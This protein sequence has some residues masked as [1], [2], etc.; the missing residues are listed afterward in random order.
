DNDPAFAT[1]GGPPGN[2]VVDPNFFLNES[3][4]VAFET[5]GAITGLS[6]IG[7]IS[8]G[9]PTNSVWSESN[10]TCG[11]IYLW[12]P[13]GGLQKI[14]AAGDAAP[15]T[16]V[17]FSCV[18]L[19]SGSPSPL[20]SSGQV[21]FTSPSPFGAPLPC[22]LCDPFNP[23]IGMNGVFLYSPGGA[24]TEI[25][26][27]NDTLPGQTQA[28]TFVPNLSVPVNSLGQVAFGAEL[29]TTSQGFYLR[30]ADSSTEKVVA[31]PDSVPGSSATFGF[32]HFIA[33]LADNGNLAFTAATS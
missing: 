5:V 22:S 29:G 12:S 11:T 9:S 24:I 25:A 31:N 32:P 33:G 8:F 14:V 20:N 1:A 6:G 2:P 3:G 7:I 28:T 17:K 13:S 23:A 26:A 19:N 30:N 27:A 10:S 4:Q 15:N 16:S 21:A 18:T